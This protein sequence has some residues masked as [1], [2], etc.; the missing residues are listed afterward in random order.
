M[1]EG[2]RKFRFWRDNAPLAGP[3]G[4][5]GSGEGPLAQPTPNLVPVA[6]TADAAQ[7][8]ESAFGIKLL[9]PGEAPTVE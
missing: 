7:A 2:R 8:E 6:E 4:G 5:A 9:A 1:A 3:M